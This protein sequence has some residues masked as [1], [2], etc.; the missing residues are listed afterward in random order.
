M[1]L[2]LTSVAIN[3]FRCKMVQETALRGA[4]KNNFYK[5]PK[6]RKKTRNPFSVK[7]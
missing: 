4:V 1:E 7:W 5:I 6:R 2:G 3:R